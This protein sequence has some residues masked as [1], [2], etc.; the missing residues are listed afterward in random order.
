VND[1]VCGGYKKSCGV[2]TLIL[3]ETCNSVD[4]TSDRPYTLRYVSFVTGV[5]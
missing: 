5:L 2:P 3:T 1:I 4:F